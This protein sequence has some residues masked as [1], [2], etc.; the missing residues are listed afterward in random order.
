MVTRA[1]LSDTTRRVLRTIY[2]SAVALVGVTP[3][4]LTLVQK[5]TNYFPQGSWVYG[6]LVAFGVLAT[7]IVGAV[8]R[9][10]IFLEGQKWFPVLIARQNTSDVPAVVAVEVDNGVP[11]QA[12]VVSVDTLIKEKLHEQQP[13][14]PVTPSVIIE[15]NTTDKG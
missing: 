7:A 4:V 3:L 10:L 15:G 11:Q 14:T 6:K 9:V 1:V 5:L 13:N 2:Q 8:A 12:E